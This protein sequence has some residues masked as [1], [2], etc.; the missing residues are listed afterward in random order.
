MRNDIHHQ[1]LR[2]Q[3]TW[4]IRSLHIL[5]CFA[6]LCRLISIVA[7]MPCD[8]SWLQLDTSARHTPILTSSHDPQEFSRYSKQFWLLVKFVLVCSSCQCCCRKLEH[9]LGHRSRVHNFCSNLTLMS[10]FNCAPGAGC[11]SKGDTHTLIQ[12]WPCTAMI[13]WHSLLFQCHLIARFNLA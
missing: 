5:V 13:Y 4:S 10:K 11:L 7:Y 1:A 2:S 3:I 9:L 6:W 12:A 8:T